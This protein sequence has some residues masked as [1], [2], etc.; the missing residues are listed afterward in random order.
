MTTPRTRRE[1]LAQAGALAAAPMLSALPAPVRREEGAGSPLLVVVFLRGGA[2][3][4][5]MLAPIGDP[6]YRSVRPTLALSKE[7]GAIPLDSEF[8]LHPALTAL[9]PLWDAKAFAPIVCTG[10]P[11][12]T[13]SHFDAQDFM[14]RAAPGLRDVKSGWLDRYLAA[15]TKKDASEFR[16][17]AL[18]TLLPRALRGEHGALAVAPGQEKVTGE[19]TLSEFEGLY[20]EDMAGR[21]DAGDVA[22]SGHATIETLRRFNAIVEKA[23]PAK[24]ALYPRSGF[25]RRLSTLAALARADCGLE[26][27]ALDYTGWDHHIDQGAVEGDHAR[28]LADYAESLAAFCRDL[29]ERLDRTLIVTMTEFG[30]TVRENGNNGSDHGR[31][32]GTFLVG[33]G[34]RGGRVHGKWRGLADKV[35]VDARDLPVTTDFRDV[36]AASLDALFGFD[37]PKD[38]FPEYKPRSTTL[39]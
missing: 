4:L 37:P 9:K 15:T 23:Q 39:F 22:A 30:R 27:A 7:T 14:E 16:A 5:N 38:F 35:L 21:A 32:A 34:V 24:E 33:G 13:R 18:Q 29:G 25:A 1:F 28:R 8:A 19:A 3:F 12:E 2:D 36:F 31:G 6:I 20:G 26:V 17:V 11:H 10:S